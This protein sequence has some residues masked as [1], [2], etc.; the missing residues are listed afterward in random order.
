MPILQRLYL[1]NRA[2]KNIEDTSPEISDSNSYSALLSTIPYALPKEIY[3]LKV[4]LQ[5]FFVLFNDFL[6][7]NN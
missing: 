6:R 1:H 3:I 7:E 5:R 4:D 2:K